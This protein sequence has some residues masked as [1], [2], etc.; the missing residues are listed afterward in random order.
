MQ[1]RK[2]LELRPPVEWDKGKA[3]LWLLR[4]QEILKGKGNVLSDLHWR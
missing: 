3:A 2:V 4:K 1:E